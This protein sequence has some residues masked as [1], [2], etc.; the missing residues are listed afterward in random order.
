[1]RGFS[2]LIAIVFCIGLAAGVA[3]GQ[4]AGQRTRD[5]VAALDKTKYKKKEKRDFSIE[6]Y[7]DIKNDPTV[8]SSPAEYAGVYESEDSGYKLELNVSAGGAVTGSGHD[9]TNSDSAQKLNF[10][11]KDARIEGALLTATKVYENGQ[12]LAFEAAFVNRTI[13]S[14]KNPNDIATRYTRFGVGFI[15]SGNEKSETWTNRVFLE[16]R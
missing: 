13:L 6:I 10:T 9:T 5:L 16:R 2:I 15:Q 1:M 8:K 4:D 12:S 11:L 7:V 14:G 3:V